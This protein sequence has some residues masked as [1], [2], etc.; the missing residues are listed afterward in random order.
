[1][2]DREITLVIHNDE[3]V[4][5]R[6]PGYD[7][8]DG[9]LDFNNLRLNTINVFKNWLNADKITEY[10]ELVV[11]GRHLY[12]GLF[13]SSKLVTTFEQ[14]WDEA[15]KYDQK[16][17]I[18]L[19]FKEEAWKHGLA[20]LPWEYLYHPEREFLAIDLNCIFARYM[21]LSSP[22]PATLEIPD[23]TVKILVVVSQPEALRPVIA[24]GVIDE[25]KNLESAAKVNI[26]ELQNPTLEEF[27]ESLTSFTPHIV[28]WVGH[29]EYDSSKGVCKIAGVDANRT[30]RWWPDRLFAMKFKDIEKSPPY[31]VVL[32]MCETGK[33]DSHDTLKFSGSFTGVAPRL[34]ESQIPAVVAMQYP[35]RQDYAIGFSTNFYKG[36]AERDVDDAFQEARRAIY[37]IDNEALE[38][39]IFGT[40]VLYWRSGLGRMFRTRNLAELSRPSQGP[41]VTTSLVGRAESGSVADAQTGSKE[42]K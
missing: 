24:D 26:Q 20:S 18:Q 32:Q 4:E 14:A 25:I 1:M 22:R 40:P 31:L 19:T 17:R 37:S 29:G 16:L 21:A 5:L 33:T 28:H 42:I 39:G 13:A 9:I 2:S 34:M 30:L 36:L 15:R 11:L 38:K 8:V 12:E 27:G 6:R 35:I 23:R 7:A 3:K 10:G 41:P